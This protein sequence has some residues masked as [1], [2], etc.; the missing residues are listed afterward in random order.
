M[1]VGWKAGAIV[2]EF[3]CWRGRVGARFR[4]VKW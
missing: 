2:L 3:G 4:N 1:G